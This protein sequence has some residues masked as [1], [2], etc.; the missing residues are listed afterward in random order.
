MKSEP[1]LSPGRNCWKVARA[2]RANFLID[3]AAYYKAFAEVAERAQRLIF[4]TAWDIDGQ[5]AL[6]PARPKDNL[7]DFLI[8]LLKEKPQLHVYILNWK[9]TPLFTR[10][11]EMLPL[12]DGPWH[13]HPRL[14]FEWD[15]VHPAGA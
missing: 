8:R 5:I 4:L 15:S 11:R 7:R 13:Q 1:L 3:A 14:H 12:F 10:D 6:D 2:D 9:F